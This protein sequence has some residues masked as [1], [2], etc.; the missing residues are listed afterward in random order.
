[1][2]PAV[3]ETCAGT[4]CFSGLVILSGILLLVMLPAFTSEPTRWMACAV[5]ANVA[6]KIFESLDKPV[7][8]AAGIVS[9][10]TL[11]HL[12]AGL[13]FVPLVIWLA[14][15]SPAEANPARVSGPKK[16][17]EVDDFIAAA[18]SLS[19]NKYTSPERLASKGGS[20]GGWLVGAV[21]TQ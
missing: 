21:M 18:E 2:K 10:H 16:R 11:K 6:A 14:T 7:F 13:G 9:G 19:K 1:M 12:S 20:N 17:E 8:D 5:I 15:Q 3:T 4:F